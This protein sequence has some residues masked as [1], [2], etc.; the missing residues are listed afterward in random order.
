M[1]SKIF[2]QTDLPHISLKQVQNGFD[3]KL[4]KALTPPLMA[5]EVQRFDGCNLNDEVHLKVGFLFPFQKWVSVI[6]HSQTSNDRF[7]FIDEGKFVP[8]PL[9][10]W[11]HLHIVEKRPRGVAIV[12]SIEYAT[13]FKLL[14]LLIYP[15]LFL[16]FYYR[17]SAYAKFFKEST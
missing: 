5:I 6:T 13:P 3:V 9:R 17:K 11:R 10:Y 12:D 14:D 4:F 1:T 2:I 15:V 8:F 16:Q 7:E